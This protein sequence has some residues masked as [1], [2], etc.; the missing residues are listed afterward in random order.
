MDGER[1]GGAGVTS[2]YRAGGAG[3][4]KGGGVVAHRACADVGVVVQHGA[5]AIVAQDT[6]SRACWDNNSTHSKEL[7]PAAWPGAA[8]CE[9]GPSAGLAY[10]RTWASEAQGMSRGHPGDDRL[11]RR[12]EPFRLVSVE[13]IQ[14]SAVVR[15]HWCHLVTASGRHW[16]QMSGRSDCCTAR[17]AACAKMTPVA[18]DVVEEGPAV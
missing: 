12:A 5:S 16:A 9:G 13:D 15:W 1:A 17:P 18:M 7:A 10:P 2:A 6:Y 4:G 3:E 14:G 11:H 8:Q